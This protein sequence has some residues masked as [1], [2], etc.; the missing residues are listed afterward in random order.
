MENRDVRIPWSCWEQN[1]NVRLAFDVEHFKIIDTATLR[2]TRVLC[3]RV[4]IQVTRLANN[5]KDRKRS[6]TMI[7]M[8]FLFIFFLFVEKKS[9]IEHDVD[10]FTQRMTN[11]VT[12][13]HYG[14]NWSVKFLLLSLIVLVFFRSILDYFSD[15]IACFSILSIPSACVNPY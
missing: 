13:L 12:A 15:C 2:G 8:A 9:S 3:I 7:A 1:N 5:L 11:E 14:F 10:S 4:H 6:H